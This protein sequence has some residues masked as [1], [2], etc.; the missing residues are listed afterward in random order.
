MKIFSSAQIRA[1]DADT[2]SSEPIAAIGLMERAAARCA[3]W[4]L[5]FPEETSFHIFCGPGNNGGDGLLIAHQLYAKG[6][7][8]RTY[9]LD[10]GSQGSIDFREARR[11]LEA[12][13]VPMETIRAQGAVPEIPKGAIIVDAL[14]GTGLTKPLGSAAARLV[15]HLNRVAA[16][17]VSIDL[18][19]GLFADT[20][21]KDNIILKADHTLTFAA[22]KLA[23]L[24]QE[25]GPYVGKLHI[26]DIGLSPA[27]AEE[28]RSEFDYV[29]NALLR[30]LH[31]PRNPFAH[32]GNFGHALLVAG[33]FGKMGAAIMAAG[34]CLRGGTGLLSCH[35]PRC[36]VAIMQTA[37][38][39]AMVLPDADEELLTSIPAT[40]D[41]F[42]AIGIGPGIGT[43]DATVELLERYLQH[44]GCPF[45]VDAD[46]LNILAQ[47]P[48]WLQR[49]PAGS[50]LTPHPKEFDRLFG[51]HDSDFARISTALEQTRK[52]RVVVVLKG[53]HSFVA[54]PGGHG[55]FNSSGNA[56]MA[57]GGSGDA[58]T[59]LLTALLAQGYPAPD[60]AVL[61]V[62]LHGRAGDLGLE[63]EAP[64]SLLPTDLI[65]NFGAAFRELYPAE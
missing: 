50:I 14:F 41:P 15:D 37:L 55:F 16:T 11:R 35:L 12:A 5:H 58:L 6:R 54:T 57:K 3:E 31:R 52:L 33:A 28:T 22:P 21:S 51:R 1:W 26:L 32:K 19:S 59:G 44:A 9:I 64:E 47:H 49:L 42:R 40:L 48:Y 10:T 53:H 18:P 25:N 63:Q 36:G 24:L 43:G 29:D 8:L 13:G 34:A 30:S 20:S 62:W 38:P 56:G 23:L 65:G 27:F 39:E 61:G 60:A 45:V 4:L 2:I 46:A 17:R 7:S